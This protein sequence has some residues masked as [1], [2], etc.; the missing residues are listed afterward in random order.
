MTIYNVYHIITNGD[1]SYRKKTF[2]YFKM[3]HFKVLY[4]INILFFTMF[5]H[6]VLYVFPQIYPF[7]F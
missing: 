3:S 2:S 7:F 5:F 4:K 6:C 1:K